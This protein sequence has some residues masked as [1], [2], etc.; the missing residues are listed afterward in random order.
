[1]T[2]LVLESPA[3]K[4]LSLFCLA[5]FMAASCSNSGNPVTGAPQVK[6]PP[7]QTN[8]CLSHDEIAM[9][10]VAISE[11]DYQKRNEIKESLFNESR[12]SSVCRQSLI[13]SVVRIMDRPLSSY[14]NSAD[15]LHVWRAGADMLGDLK[16]IEA[17]DFL[18]AHLDFTTGVYSTMMSQQPALHAVIAIGESAIPKLSDALRQNPDWRMRMDA[19]YCISGIGGPA[20]ERT[21]KEALPSESDPCVKPFIQASIKLLNDRK[22]KIDNNL[23]W[24]K[25][26]MCNHSTSGE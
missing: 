13:E 15:R 4:I 26:F 19:V 23:E 16:A 3:M 25:A 2:R 11:S 6:P 14:K 5:F 8:G 10:L 18:V 17:I 24:F 7:V 9:K 21:L 1:M 20:A 12:K 22:Q